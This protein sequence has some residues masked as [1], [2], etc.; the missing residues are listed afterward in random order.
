MKCRHQGVAETGNFQLRSRL[1]TVSTSFCILRRKKLQ[2]GLMCSHCLSPSFGCPLRVLAPGVSPGFLASA[3]L[4]RI[5]GFRDFNSV[6][7]Y[8]QGPVFLSSSVFSMF[9]VLYT[10]INS[11]HV[12]NLPTEQATS[13]VTDFVRGVM[14]LHSRL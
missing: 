11:V 10:V 5:R 9:D 6:N 13:V 2:A 14:T 8:Q 7:L 1:K 3:V 12:Q 4:K